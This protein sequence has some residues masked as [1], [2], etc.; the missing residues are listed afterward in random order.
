MEKGTQRQVTL[1]AE[2]GIAMKTIAALL[3]LVA[4]SFVPAAVSFAQA[5]TPE[6]KAAVDLPPEMKQHV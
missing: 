5:G 3:L 1:S 4:L 2:E 6:K